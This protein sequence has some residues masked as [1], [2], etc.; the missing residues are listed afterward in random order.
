[1]N[2]APD[3]PL[4]AAILTGFFVFAGAAITLL[5]TV[6][7]VTFKTFY[8]RTHAPT[9]GTTAGAASIL[10]SS[11]ICFTALESRPVVHEVL[12]LVFITVTT[13]VTLI[14]VARATLQRD[15]NEISKKSKPD[16]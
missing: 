11:I 1:M 7:L 12:L 15:R 3:L 4:W 16:E 9:L 8:A 2:E 5:G 10:L 13:P 6:G 14:L